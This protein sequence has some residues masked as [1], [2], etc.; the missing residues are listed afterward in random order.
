MAAVGRDAG[1]QGPTLLV[2]APAI[3]VGGE[4]PSPH[5]WLL[6][7]PL[8]VSSLTQVTLTPSP[9]VSVTC[10]QPW[11]KMLNGKF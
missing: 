11:S 3:R 2:T 5:P 1:L 4:P 10:G 9:A 6:P 7:R 8:G